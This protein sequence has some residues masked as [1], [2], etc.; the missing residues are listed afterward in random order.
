MKKEISDKKLAFFYLSV[1]LFILLILGLLFYFWV[2]RPY[3]EVMNLNWGV[4]PTGAPFTEFLTKQTE[5]GLT[6]DGIRLHVMECKKPE[7]FDEKMH[8][9]DGG[10]L[11]ERPVP[12]EWKERAEEL[13]DILGIPAEERP[14]YERCSAFYRVGREDSRDELLV[15]WDTGTNLL[16]ILESFF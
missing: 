16:W 14:V 8:Q 13:L 5:S 12:V 1:T 11:M 10:I 9:W 7:A 4:S 6:G 3:F 15:F 2:S